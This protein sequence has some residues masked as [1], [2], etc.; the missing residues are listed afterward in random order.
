[1][2]SLVIGSTGLLGIALVYELSSRGKEVKATVRQNSSGRALN[3]LKELDVEIVNTDIRDRDSIDKALDYVDDVYHAAALFKTWLPDPGE[4][5]RTNVEGTRNVLEACLKKNV[6]RIVYTG[7]HGILG[8]TDYPEYADESTPV[9]KH[10]FAKAPYLESKYRAEQIVRKYIQQGLDIVITNP[11]GMI[12]IN[13]FGANITNKYIKSTAQD[14]LPKFYVDAYVCL[15]DSRDVAAGH[16]LAMEKGKK[17]ERYLLGG[18]NITFK[19]YFS[20]LYELAEIEG[21]LIEI[22][23]FLLLPF[24]YFLKWKAEVFSSPPALTPD[25]VKFLMK[26]TRYSSRKAQ[27]ELGYR[28]RPVKESIREVYQWF[29]KASFEK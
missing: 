7:S 5:E 22:P 14:K 2:K 19:E 26:R 4:F 18:E 21:T 6:R 15:V 24:S 16:V 10:Q 9:L 12:G 17:G 25:S 27:E 1:M 29:K 20:Y 8:L 3:L 13:D 11:V 28:F 23:L